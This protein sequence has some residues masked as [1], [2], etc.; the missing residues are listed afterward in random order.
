[1]KKVPKL[2][3]EQQQ[4]LAAFLVSSKRSGKEVRRAGAVQ[5][6][7]AH[8]YKTLTRQTGFSRRQAFNLR[9]A[10]REQG[11][12]ALRDRPKGKPKALLTKEQRTQI[13]SW[14]NG[15]TPEDFGYQGEIGWTTGML[16][17]V[18]EKEFSVTYK[19]KTSYYLIFKEATFTY[20]KPGRVY[21]LR[22]EAEVVAWE[23]STYPFLQTAWEN[24]NTVILC[25]DEM[26]LSS[27]TTVQKVWLPKG[28]YPLI[29]VA[30]KR[31]SKSLFGYLNLKTGQEH[32][33][34]K[35]WQNMYTTVETLTEIRKIYPDQHL[36]ILL[37]QAGWHKGSVPREWIEKDQNTHT[38]YFPRSAPDENPQEHVW[39]AG[40]VAI[41]HNQTIP[42]ITK[43][44]YEL[45]EYLNKETFPYTLLGLGAV[46]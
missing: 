8:E 40:R 38:L 11:A 42:D 4:L 13:E 35:D 41:T 39:K 24:T 25:L 20:H 36:F 12:E 32:A 34:V 22:D 19:S 2:T 17:A 21:Q 46:S 16:G 33:F 43:T 10:Y 31:E 6:V 28:Q 27:Q 5:L 3:E 18:I 44:A 45:A 1:M 15:K 26:S 9:K 30:T 37:D 7:D 23:A 29:D 14:L